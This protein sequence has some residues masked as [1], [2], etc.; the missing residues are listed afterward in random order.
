[1]KHEAGMLAIAML[2]VGI[3][4]P[5]L[6]RGLQS[7][8]TAGSSQK[9][10]S[11]ARLS[12]PS[13][14]AEISSP[15]QSNRTSR[16]PVFDNYVIGPG[17]VVAITVWKD[18]DL[19]RTMPVR[20]DGKISLPVIGEVQAAGLSAL[21]LQAEIGERLREYVRDPQINVIVQEVRS[22]TF[23]V[24]GKVNKSGS[25]ELVKPTTVLDAI[26]LA[27]GF[28][29]FAR[30]T[31]MYVLRSKPDGS[32]TLLR[33]NYKRVVK[34]EQTQQNSLLQAGDTVVVP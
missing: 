14:M 33:F 7:S 26:A 10:Q 4:S 1:M 15:T 31:K 27:G 9:M 21:R 20:P 5:P 19:S 28:Q 13:S 25:F 29:E 2:S 16:T 17:D 3:A 32:Q 8:A 30:V 18:A 22:C 24:V 11:E 34:G 12:A 23:N 6:G